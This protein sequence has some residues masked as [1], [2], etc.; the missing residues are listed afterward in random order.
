MNDDMEVE[1][2]NRSGGWQNH[3]IKVREGKKMK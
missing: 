3:Q 1:S 2:K